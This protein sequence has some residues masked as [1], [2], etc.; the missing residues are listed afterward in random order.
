MLERSHKAKFKEKD[1]PFL[2]YMYLPIS[3]SLILLLKYLLGYNDCVN[4]FKK[5]IFNYIECLLNS[6]E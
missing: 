4:N 2:Q 3:T 1:R 6:L 5:N